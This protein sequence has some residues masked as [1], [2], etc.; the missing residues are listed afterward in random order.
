MDFT[1]KR[2]WRE[3]LGGRSV[4]FIYEPTAG[5]DLKPRI[6]AEWEQGGLVRWGFENA[7]PI[8]GDHFLAYV[9]GA[10]GTIM[11]MIEQGQ[12]PTVLG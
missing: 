10:V 4:L 8:P 3:R 12:N 1:A 11:T 9:R 5:Y 2:Q 7:K 6:A